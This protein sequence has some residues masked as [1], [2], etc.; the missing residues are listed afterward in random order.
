MIN[1]ILTVMYVCIGS[2]M[3]LAAIESF[4]DQTNPARIGTG[5]FWSLMAIIFA[6][7]DLIPSLVIGILIVIIGL[8]ALFKQIRVGSVTQVNPKQA[9]AGAQKLGLLIFVPSIVLAMVSICIT[10]FTNLGGQVGIGIGA[11]TSFLLALILTRSSGRQVYH[12]TQ[13]MVRSI[14]TAGVLPQLLATLGAVFTIAGVGTLTA[15][16]IADIFPAG[17]HLGGVILY[18]VAMAIFT[19]IMGNGFAA[20]AV[21]T[22]AIGIP[23]VVVQGGNPAVVAAIGMTSGYCG[24]LITPMAA[25]FNSLPVALMEIKDQMAVIKQQAP[26]AVIL[27]VIQIALMYLLAF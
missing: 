27:L 15:K 1:L 3:G 10:Q 14:G 21:I 20:F 13:R 12:D 19:A 9:A 6:F 5:L 8:L 4:R 18:C 26:I 24:T 11:I 23:F 22:A 17:N 16:L 25:N 2:M 7:A